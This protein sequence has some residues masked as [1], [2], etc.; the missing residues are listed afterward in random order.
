MSNA[1]MG[2]P[3]FIGGNKFIVVQVA[4][5]YAGFNGAA[6]FH[7]RKFIT[8]HARVTGVRRAS[9]GPPIF[10]GGNAAGTPPRPVEPVA[11]MGPPIFIGGNYFIE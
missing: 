3:I 10:I 8:Q 7:R 6:D 1:S 9:M 11:S 2:P 4:G 5:K